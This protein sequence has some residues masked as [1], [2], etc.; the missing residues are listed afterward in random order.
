MQRKPGGANNLA[1]TQAVNKRMQR[2]CK[3]VKE[4]EHRT[5]S[6]TLLMEHS[7]QTRAVEKHHIMSQQEPQSKFSPL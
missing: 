1:K 5:G 4:G 3:Q 7:I 6:R 2:Q